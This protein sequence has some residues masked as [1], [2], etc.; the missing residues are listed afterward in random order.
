MH[1]QVDYLV[2][3]SGLSSLSFASLMARSRHSVKILEAHEHFGGYGHTFTVG[4]YHFNA[5]LH[6]V[7]GCGEGESVNLF[8]KKIGL[9]KKVTF[10]LL[11]P[12]GYDRVYC[13]DKKLFIPNG[14]EHLEERMASVSPN[15]KNEIAKFVQ[16]LKNFREVLDHWPNHLPP[17]FNF[18]KTLPSCLKLMKYRNATLQEVFDDCRLPQILQT[19]VSGQLLDYML[20]P[21]QLSFVVWA[22]L[23]T[24]Y[25]KGAYYPEKHFSHVINS[26]IKTIEE[27]GGALIPNERV[28]EFII[29]N[30]CV[31]G[32]LTQTVNPKTGI[33][34]GPKK[35]YFGKNVICNFDPKQA[36][37]M[38]GLE[39]FSSNL[40]RRLD[41][42][43]SPS[44]FVLY[45]V[46]KDL[47]LQEYGFGDWNIWHCQPDANQAFKK[48][49]EYNDYSAPYFGMN[50][51][52]LHTK[53]QSHCNREGHQFFEMI[54]A[55]NYEYWKTLKLRDK[56]TYNL[57][58]QE[59]LDQMLDVVEK[60]Y[61]P[62]IREHLVFKMTGSPTTSER[63]VNAP[64]G[65]SYGLNLTPR[66]FQFSRKLTSDTSLE[67]FHFCC[68]ASG[69]GG[70]GGTIYTGSLLYESLTGD[71]FL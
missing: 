18:L 70:F 28:V 36:A 16:I 54:T 41:Y 20:P 67:N 61:V 29:E 12:E 65:G 25:C 38:I 57:K 53:D 13:E 60:H 24:A 11:N 58:K 27:H 45:G 66:N 32:V 26:L 62:S 56:R 42:D 17:S 39:K 40:Q 43:Y 7:I 5:Q 47:D 52:S 37:N 69:Y 14:L 63:Y 51:R 34:S 31:K 15:A 59:V 35:E 68:A 6:Y 55:A 49:Y 46:V 8:L 2:L 10:N 30:N 3:G 23:F 50:S 21:N 71:Y 19:L 44:N 4:D 64:E 22:A 9:E 48:M 1:D 33:F